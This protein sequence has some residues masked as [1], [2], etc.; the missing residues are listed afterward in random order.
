MIVTEY[1]GMA[2]FFKIS[3]V[4][5]LRVQKLCIL[6]LLFRNSV[7]VI[8]SYCANDRGYARKGFSSVGTV[9]A[10]HVPYISAELKYKR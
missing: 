4:A 6:H 1:R 9:V 2:R 7:E 5:E 8:V 10:F 3:S